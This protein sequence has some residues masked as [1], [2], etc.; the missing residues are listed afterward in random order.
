LELEL[1]AVREELETARDARTLEDAELARAR[2]DLQGM[3]AELATATEQAS[4]CGAELAA[5]TQ[6]LEGLSATVDETNER[7]RA[8]RARLATLDGENAG[9][10]A[11]LEQRDADLRDTTDRS[12]QLRASL[13]AAKRELESFGAKGIE[14]D[15]LLAERDA[16]I[17]SLNGQLDDS[18]SRCRNE[19]GRAD[20]LYE[21]KERL[22]VRAAELFKEAI[23][24][25]GE[26]DKSRLEHE[27]TKAT[28]GD[29]Q[30]E[31]DRSRHAL[32]KL[33]NDLADCQHKLNEALL[34]E[35]QVERE[36]AKLRELDRAQQKEL[37]VITKARTYV[38]GLYDDLQKRHHSMDVSAELLKLEK[39]KL[40][41]ENAR[42]RVELDRLQLDVQR[43]ARERIS[44]LSLQQATLA[45]E[46]LRKEL[47]DAQNTIQNLR[48]DTDAFRSLRTLLDA[49]VAEL[50][51][52]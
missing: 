36:V 3:R 49:H 38:Q 13:D 15:R 34:K 9:L 35:D 1:A 19:R 25:R 43:L 29:V 40:A 11:K 50:Q 24:A 6:R 22:D 39:T 23:A 46:E 44:D 17:A 5:R 7:L 18:E 2:A 12:S 20:T 4:A 26:R 21:E 30:R 51:R 52:T 33:T 48:A 28:L 45:I 31:L 14:R 8:E 37:D 41:G 10:R 32:A 27:K 42:F 16:Q 47:I